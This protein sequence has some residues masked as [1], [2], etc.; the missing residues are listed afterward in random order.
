LKEKLSGSGLSRE[1]IKK[2][3]SRLPDIARHSSERERAA[4]EAERASIEI[5]KAQFMEG[6]IGE[7]FTGIVSGV[8]GFGLFVE[9]DNTI[10]GMI[11]VNELKDDY[12]IYNERAA[13]LTG[14]RS[15][16]RY[17]LGDEIRVKVIRAS[18]EEGQVTF[19]PDTDD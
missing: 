15:G 6:K 2:L 11:P 1:K 3:H 18:R 16:K 9:L 8:A 10:E 14:E 5:K 4:V 7:I 17:K 12:Y 19:M 13:S